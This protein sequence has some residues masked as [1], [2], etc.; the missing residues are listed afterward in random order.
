MRVLSPDAYGGGEVAGSRR[1]ASTRLGGIA[2]TC[3]LISAPNLLRSGRAHGFLENVVSHP[4]LRGL[5]HGSAVVRAA[6]GEALG[7]KTYFE[8]MDRAFPLVTQSGL[9][10]VAI[11]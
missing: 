2:R 4:Q 8:A 7:T 11:P 3:M 5:G 1:G 10:N 9:R 6:L